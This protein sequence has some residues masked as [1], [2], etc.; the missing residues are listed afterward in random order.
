MREDV[1]AVLAKLLG[2]GSFF[3][4]KS[5]FPDVYPADHN[6]WANSASRKIISGGVKHGENAS[7]ETKAIVEDLKTLGVTST[8]LHTF[9]HTV[10]P[11]LS[12]LV[13]FI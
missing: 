1:E 5:C 6:D 2:F 10:I 3:H 9:Y 12:N 4:W 8:R 11:S 7:E 13:H